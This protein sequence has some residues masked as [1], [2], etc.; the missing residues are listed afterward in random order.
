MSER[1]VHV[2]SIFTKQNSVQYTKHNI[3]FYFIC[4]INP[5]GKKQ[6]NA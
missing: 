6:C 1:R 2:N 3:I 5:N 4:A